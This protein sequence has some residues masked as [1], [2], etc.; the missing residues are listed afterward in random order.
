M[1]TE[2]HLATT[3]Y[4]SYDSDMKIN[5]KQYYTPSI[6]VDIVIFT[7]Q[8]N[9]LKVLLVNRKQEPFKGSPALPGGFLK[10]DETTLDTVKRILQDKVGIQ[11]V[12]TEQLFTFDDLK[13]DPRGP[14]IS[15]AYFSIIPFES[16]ILQES[17]HTETPHFVDIN[18]LPKLAFDHKKIISYAVERL[19][20]KLEYTNVSYS[21]LPK[22]FTLTDLQKIY[23]A[24]L[25]RPM[26]KRNFRKKFLQLNLIEETGKMSPKGRQRPAKMHRFKKLKLMELKKFF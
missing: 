13:R 19:Q 24:V 18:I 15:I 25:G 9:R 5:N 2:K 8:D 22:E 26:D 11:N 7:I 4:E 16:I 14:V 23:E 20:S 17:E 21:L 6:T 1:Y 12:Y 10:E 3:E